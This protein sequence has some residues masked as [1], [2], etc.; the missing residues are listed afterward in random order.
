MLN[1]Q[2]LHT[3]LL[4]NKLHEG[5]AANYAQFFSTF[6]FKS[7]QTT[8]Q[9]ITQGIRGKKTRNYPISFN[10]Y[11]CPMKFNLI[12]GQAGQ[13][14]PKQREKE[15]QIKGETGEEEQWQHKSISA[16]KGRSC[17][18]L[19][20]TLKRDEGVRRSG[21]ACPNE[22]AL[23]SGQGNNVRCPLSVV[24]RPLSHFPVVPCPLSL[25]SVLLAHC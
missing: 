17:T 3:H 22:I 15:T 11:I 18:E 12:K 1:E 4:T 2:H 5:F 25:S 24:P 9:K 8:R 7:G 6:S 13:Q 20:K 10:V 16:P 23:S 14:K 21:W 19:T